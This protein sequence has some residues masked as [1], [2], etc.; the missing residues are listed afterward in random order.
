[1]SYLPMSC[2]AE[3]AVEVADPEP[4]PEE[5]PDA[6]GKIVENG[7]QSPTPSKNK[8]R[9]C[10]VCLDVDSCLYATAMVLLWP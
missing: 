6:E 7:L 8:A 9:R 5:E 3:P 2:A 10:G 1:M 4:E